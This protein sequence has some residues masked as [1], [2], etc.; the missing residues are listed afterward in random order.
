[1][2]P[3]P[4][5]VALVVAGDAFT[6]KDLTDAADR[7]AA[8]LLAGRRDLDDA[9]IAFAVAPGFAYAAVM[10]GIWRAGGVA[11][12]LALAHPPAE[13]DHVIRDA[14]A[15][16]V[17]SN[18]DR[19][20]RLEPL[21]LAAGARFVRTADLLATASRAGVDPA[22]DRRAL[23][24]YTSG[25]TGKPK[26]V[27]T[28][29]AQLAAQIAALVSAWE[30]TAADRALLVLPLHHVHG[31]VNL[32][33]SALAV[34]GTCEVLHPF[35]P[36]ATW[37]R[38][39][40]GEVTVFSAVPTIY[41]RLIQSWDSAPSEV[42]RAW[43]AGCRGVRL[44]MSGSAALPAS[45]LIRWRELTGHTLLERYGM[46]EIGMGLSNPLRG[47]RRP[48]FVGAPLPDVQAR[49]V[50]ERGTPMEE[51]SPGELEIRGPGVFREYWRRP[52]ETAQAFRDGWFRTGDVAVVEGGTYRLLGRTSV[53]IIKTGGYKVSAL[54]IE[55]VLREHPTVA[56]CAVVALPDPMWGERVC[57][58]VEPRPGRAISSD[59]L[60]AWAR[61]RLAPYKVPKDVHAVSELPRNAMGKVVKPDVARILAERCADAGASR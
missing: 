11:V 21:T 54:E 44:M 29:H 40:S 47:D 50:D 15:S 56:D 13:L 30:W 61:E 55:D 22:P 57:A 43:S 1:M 27:V 41:Y 35:E 28:T 7:V 19:S 59:E 12:P 32:L 37:H 58:A 48:G 49:I 10:Q 25:T 39:A 31:I 16:V 60:I 6:Y 51:G 38:L 8:G 5:R 2:T 34:G 18:A 14:G 17:V 33:C 45:T 9:R 52:E 23:I 53:D 26:G 3:D 42:Q 36:A 46:T 4:S 20:A 24:L